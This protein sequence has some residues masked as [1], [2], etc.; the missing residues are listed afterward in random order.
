MSGRISDELQAA[1]DAARQCF[2]LPALDGLIARARY[3]G[4]AALD[5]LA[6]SYASCVGEIWMDFDCGKLT[7]RAG[8]QLTAAQV[9]PDVIDGFATCRRLCPDDPGYALSEARA[10]L[11]LADE[12]PDAAATEAAQALATMD[13]LLAGWTA[14]D[15]G[16]PKFIHEGNLV[17]PRAPGREDV[18]ELRAMALFALALHGSPE[19]AGARAAEACAAAQASIEVQAF[20]RVLSVWLHGAGRLLACDD[21]RVR[22][23]GDQAMRAFDSFAASWT[24]S[25]PIDARWW[26]ELFTRRSE[27]PPEHGGGPAALARAAAIWRGYAVDPSLT[28]RASTEIGHLIQRCGRSLGDRDLLQRALAFHEDA[29][30]RSPDNFQS[31]YVA[32]ACT[33]LAH[34][35]GTPPDERIAWYNRAV[36]ACRRHA[37][38]EDDF[39]FGVHFSGLLLDRASRFAYPPGHPDIEEAWRR[40][41]ALIASH[42]GSYLV[43]SEHAAWARLLQGRDDDAF[44][45]LRDGLARIGACVSVADLAGRPWFLALGA[46]RAA[47]LRRRLESAQA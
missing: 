41:D 17:S 38:P 36:D 27:V 1:I 14:P 39:H 11:D 33:D 32:E 8:N 10:R 25:R 20:D 9:L 18:H 47:R 43:Q 26:G 28:P 46:E 7:D 29:L 5:A 35:P 4:R 37:M 2:D 24:A 15:T 34:L 22:T 3:E 21:P 16:E 44:A 42:G 12:D 23:A 30:E 19:Q 13:Q 31:G 40:S 45:I 6:D